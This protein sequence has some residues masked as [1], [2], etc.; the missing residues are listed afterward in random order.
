MRQALC[1]SKLHWLS[2]SGLDSANGQRHRCYTMVAWSS[3]VVGLRK[4]SGDVGF[5][6]SAP[7]HSVGIG[8]MNVATSWTRR[9]LSLRTARRQRR[10][11]DSSSSTPARTNNLLPMLVNY[12]TRSQ[13]NVTIVNDPVAALAP[14][15]RFISKGK[16]RRVY[17]DTY[18]ECFAIH[19]VGRYAWRRRRR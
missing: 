15:G 12:N 16:P 18:W 13:L 6:R 7:N 3:R 4:R 10:V 19:L 1:Q 9:V 17:G 11:P 14:V 8:T 5:S 2:R